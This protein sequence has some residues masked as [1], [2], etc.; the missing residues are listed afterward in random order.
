[1]LR[2][3]LSG[4]R[5][6]RRCPSHNSLNPSSR[7]FSTSSS[8]AGSGRRSNFP[9][10]ATAVHEA[11]SFPDAAGVGATICRAIRNGRASRTAL[12][13]SAVSGSR[14]AAQKSLLSPPRRRNVNPRWERPE[15]FSGKQHSGE[16][17]P[18]IAYT[19]CYELKGERGISGY[20]H[21]ARQQHS[22]GAFGGS[23]VT[24]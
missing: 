6:L 8:L 24:A 18:N 10:F 20:E 21:S 3:S 16:A 4:T 19:G 2:Y 7:Y 1:V 15:K 12:G 22:G 23:P 17:D 14:A 5:R 11:P 13:E 9:V